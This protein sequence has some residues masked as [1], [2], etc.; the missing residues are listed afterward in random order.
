MKHVG[1]ADSFLAGAIGEPGGRTFLL[2][3]RAGGEVSWFLVEKRQV[4]ALALESAQVLEETG[5]SGAGGGGA[6][7]LGAPDAVRFRVAQI[8]LVYTEVSGLIDIV[9]LPA[10]PE[11]DDAVGFSLTPV[12]LDQMARAAAAAVERGRPACPRCGLAMDPE[13]HPCP[14]DNGDLREHRP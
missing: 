14:V 13:G 7:E 1:A 8:E 5:F 6:T 12:Q 4:A 3:L 11:R 2:E 9:L 10:D